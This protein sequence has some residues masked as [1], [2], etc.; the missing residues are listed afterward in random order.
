ML[1]YHLHSTY[2]LDSRMSME[3]ACMRAIEAGLKEIAF[4]DHID[5]DW[6][7]DSIP[8]FDIRTLDRYFEDIEKMQDM[9]K[10]QL[11]IKKGIEIGLQPHILEKCTDI[12][13]AYPFDFVIASVHIVGGVDP[14][15]GTFYQ[16]KTKEESYRQ[17]YEEI[18]MLIK[19]FDAFNVLGHLDYI[20]RYSP[21]PIEETDH[22]LCA[23]L[24]DEILKTLISKDKGLEVNTSG[25]RHASKSPMP[26]PDIIARYKQ[27]G[28]SILT[29][30]SDAHAPEHVAFEFEAALNE[31]KRSGFDTLTVF[32]SMQPEFVAIP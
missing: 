19:S 17:Y 9:F 21:F 27:L 12:I 15:W 26:H 25:Y 23:T 30:G 32:T 5:I 8:P 13:K 22:L 11:V 18:L 4:T 1:D 14:Y 24:V 29:L 31:I 16:G 28:G 10:G 6:P 20:K 7:D 2:S 3:A